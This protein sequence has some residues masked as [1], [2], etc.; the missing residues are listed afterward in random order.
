MEMEKK[1]AT[2]YRPEIR[3]TKTPGSF[4]LLFLQNL[5]LAEKEMRQ[6]TLW[7]AYFYLTTNHLKTL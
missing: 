5:A 2:L 6:A 3:S 1:Q 7:Q 4:F